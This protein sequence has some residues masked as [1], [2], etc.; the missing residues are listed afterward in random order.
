M[1]ISVPSASYL[2]GGAVNGAIL[3]FVAY[4]L[5]RY[6]RDIAGRALLAVVLVATGG[7]YVGFAITAG[8]GPHWV[9][10]EL[11]QTGVLAT[12][13][14]LGLRRF[15]YWLAAGWALHPLWDIPLHLW[16]PGHAFAPEAYAVSCLTYDWAVALYV[17]IAY[18]ATG[19]TRF[20]GRRALMTTAHQES[21]QH[22]PT[23]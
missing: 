9:V 13:A 18:T 5:S 22:R 7:F 20:R 1:E 8:A 11:V 23:T 15:P 6:V 21:R 17:I 4:L 3:A 19:T 12:F 14:V 2:L 16:G 10:L